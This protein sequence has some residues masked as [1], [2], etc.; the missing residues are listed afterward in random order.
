MS[1]GIAASPG[2]AI[3]R[4]FLFRHEEPD[5]PRFAV[6]ESTLDA[7]IDRY[8][9]ALE[10]TRGE[11]QEIQRSIEQEMPESYARIF[12]AHLQFLEDPVFLTE[13]PDEIRNTLTNAEFVV[14]RITNELIS[15]LSQIDN[16]LIRGRAID[17]QDVVKRI[18][19]NL[20]DKK[21]DNLSSLTEE[22]IIV[23][24]DL[25][26][27]DTAL[28]DKDHVLGFATDVGS[29]TS[30]TAIMARALEIPAVVGLG[31]ITSQLKTGDLVIVDGNHGLVLVN[32]EEAI[33]QDYLKE[34]SR[35]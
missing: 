33:V 22:V 5:L 7:E 29:R 18:V 16:E 19:H 10:E 23:A 25:S 1:E 15:N 6:E 35:F 24:H 31:N 11:L 34:Q 14:T 30:H 28:M 26:P 17:I 12:Q 20:L 4:A 8:Q 32:P 3:G 2:V 13:I 9:S 27:S 21:R